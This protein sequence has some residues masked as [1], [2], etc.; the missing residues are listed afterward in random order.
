MKAR[1]PK[2]VKTV[3][4]K[5]VTGEQLESI[6]NAKVAER[7]N[8][9]TQ[10][11]LVVYQLTELIALH[12]YAG[13][14]NKRLNDFLTNLSEVNAWYEKLLCS[15]DNF[16]GREGENLDLA[17]VHLAR[18]AESYGI[19]WQELLGADIVGKVNPFRG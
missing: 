17:V 9:Y 3:V 15:A 16:G 13:W 4:K 2:T 19:N 5:Q 6:I 7:L 10:Q 18:R 1:L 14:S 11:A 8:E 12:E